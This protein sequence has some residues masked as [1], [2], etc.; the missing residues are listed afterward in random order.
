MTRV[1]TSF[2]AGLLVATLAIQV[3]SGCKGRSHGSSTVQ[4]SDASLADARNAAIRQFEA[5]LRHCIERR[6]APAP[7]SERETRRLNELWRM[8][9]S[10]GSGCTGCHMSRSAQGDGARLM[11][12]PDGDPKEFFQGLARRDVFTRQI[13]LA[14]LEPTPVR[15][16]LMESLGKGK[17]GL[18]GLLFFKPPQNVS[19]SD[20]ERLGRHLLSGAFDEPVSEEPLEALVTFMAE[21]GRFAVD[22]H[23]QNIVQELRLVGFNSSDP[24]KWAEIRV[25]AAPAPAPSPVP[26]QGL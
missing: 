11:V 20:L 24:A 1:S 7:L 8:M 17:L 3:V 4:G 18:D 23:V 22:H 9:S 25:V 13:A 12:Q 26:A 14:C 19:R 16:R 21:G 15:G 10:G 5:E 2:V 6:F